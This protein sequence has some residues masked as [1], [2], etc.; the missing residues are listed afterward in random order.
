MRFSRMHA[1]DRSIGRSK[2]GKKSCQRADVDHPDYVTLRQE[3]NGTFVTVGDEAIA[4][5]FDCWTTDRRAT[6]KA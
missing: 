5:S 3:L 6:D 2:W 1:R 4:E